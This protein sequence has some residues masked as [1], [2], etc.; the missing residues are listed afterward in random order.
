MARRKKPTEHQQP[1]RHTDDA[2]RAAIEA[3]Q[4]LGLGDDPSR[5]CPADRLR[6]DLVA[7]LRLV[8]DHAGATAM[9]G[10]TADI[11]RLV[12]AVEQLA[13]LLPKAATEAPSHRADPR[14]ALFDLLMQMRERG[15]I[16]DEGTMR[17]TIN[18][19]AAEIE[20]L[21]AELAALK[22][23]GAGKLVDDDVP[24]V[25]ERVP[26][27]AAKNVVPLKPSSAPAAPAAPAY[28]YD[29]ERGWR[30]HVLPDSSISPTPMSGGKWWGPV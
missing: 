7:T 25:V 15:G 14:K 18:A 13:K 21:R 9:A 20:Q 10:G 6:C 17:A 11:G 3:C 28:D 12:T 27:P 22:A 5:L 4:L 24:E 23:G 19:Q 30:D 29:K 26:A 8:I 1:A 16:P 2:E